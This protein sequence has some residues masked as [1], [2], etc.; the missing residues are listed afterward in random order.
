VALASG[1]GHFLGT[2]RKSQLELNLPNGRC[3]DAYG[4]PLSTDYVHLTTQAQVRVGKLL[5][6]AFY[7][8]DSA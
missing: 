3:V 5:A 1:Q 8:F 2:V 4:V 6:K 7:S